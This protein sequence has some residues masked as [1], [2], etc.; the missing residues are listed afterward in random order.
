MVRGG[1]F[2]IRAVSWPGLYVVFPDVARQKRS[3]ESENEAGK[4]GETKISDS[5]IPSRLELWSP[6]QVLASWALDDSTKPDMRDINRLP[7]LG[8]VEIIS[9]PLGNTNR[10]TIDE[11][12]KDG[13]RHGDGFGL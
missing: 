12:R 2:A 6:S 13:I 10:C 11:S 3:E 9:N 5:K 4:C 7:A 8:A 1:D